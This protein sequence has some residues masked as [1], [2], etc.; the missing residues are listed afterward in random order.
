MPGQEGNWIDSR[1]AQEAVTMAEQ[2]LAGPAKAAESAVTSPEPVVAVPSLSRPTTT[3]QLLVD[4][5][6][7]ALHRR[8]CEPRS[9][10]EQSVPGALVRD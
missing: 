9:G 2:S 7:L 10:G 4:Q 1:S 8:S 5:H 6:L 3:T